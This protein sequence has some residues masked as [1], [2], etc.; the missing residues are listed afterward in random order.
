MTHFFSEEMKLLK[1]LTSGILVGK[2][3]PLHALMEEHC[4]TLEISQKD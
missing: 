4:I 3:I 1:L 2:H